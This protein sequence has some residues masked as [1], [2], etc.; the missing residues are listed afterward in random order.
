MSY[1]P[2]HKGEYDIP[3]ATL[4]LA[5]KVIKLDITDDSYFVIKSCYQYIF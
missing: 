5:T 1:L 4:L 3:L 2:L